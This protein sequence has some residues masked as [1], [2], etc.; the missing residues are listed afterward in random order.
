LS[1]PDGDHE[2]EFLDWWMVGKLDHGLMDSWIDGGIGFVENSAARK[3]VNPLI[4]LSIN[5]AIIHQ[6]SYP[7]IHQSILMLT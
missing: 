6:S 4:H 5:P 1:I 2:V 3:S 7:L